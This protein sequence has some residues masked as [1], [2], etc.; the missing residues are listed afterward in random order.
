MRYVE[1]L[2]SSPRVTLGVVALAA[3]TDTLLYGLAVPVLPGY[4]AD[5]GV[6]TWA[7]GVL[8][9]SYSVALLVGT[10]IFGPLSDR[11]G[12]RA[13]MLAGLLGLGAATLLFG[14]ADTYWV[15]L[16]A[17]VLQ[18]LAAAATWT[19]GLALVADIYPAESRGAAMGTALSGSTTGMLIGPPLGGLLYEWGGYSAPFMVAGVFTLAE[20]AVLLLLL[21]DPP[22]QGVAPPALRQLL[23]DRGVQTAAG[24]ALIAAAAWGL[25]EPILPLRL[26][27]EFGFSPGG[28]GLLF[29]AATLVY[30]I[31][32]PLVGM[33]ADRW[34]ARRT[35][36]AG[37]VLTA[38]A[39]PLVGVPAVVLA[40]G[41][42]LV[43]SVA[44]GLVLTPTLP[45]LAAA[46][47]RRGGGAYASAYALFN[48]AYAAGMTAGPMLG[49]ALVSAFG[50]SVALLVTAA[51]VLGYLPAVLGGRPRGT[52]SVDGMRPSAPGESLRTADDGQ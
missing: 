42:V 25:L 48:A 51:A 9:G 24:A 5:L 27:E 14:V 37:V 35:I 33:L 50:F 10:P 18:G 30:G 43:V 44:Y 15:L 23:R 13:P 21:R 11:V 36:A 49:G 12:R 17:R 1:P 32:A 29:G 45:E 7:I 22:R 46:V 8:F 28:V 3:F 6:S 26:E 4:V 52:V 40:I 39:L 19:A 38:L 31:S 2:R 20:G 47:D 41:G 34:G 16:L